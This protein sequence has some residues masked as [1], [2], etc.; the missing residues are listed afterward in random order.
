MST[1]CL[2]YRLT[3]HTTQGVGFQK[4][5]AQDFLKMPLD[6]MLILT[7]YLSTHWLTKAH[8]VLQPRL[9]CQVLL[10]RIPLKSLLHLCNACLS[11]FSALRVLPMP[12]SNRSAFL[13][14]LLTSLQDPSPD[15][16]QS[17]F[18]LVGDLAKVAAPHI[19][20]A[21]PQLTALAVASLDLVQIRNDT[22]S[23]TNNAC[24]ALGIFPIYCFDLCV[25]IG[26]GC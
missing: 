20:P 3:L 21:L 18:A 13:Y 1:L 15:V 11:T 6:L 4:L 7:L 25:W 12:T 17:A 22:V 8:V 2:F 19:A 14:S 16:R 26:V 23:A 5:N 24:W 9:A 10:Q